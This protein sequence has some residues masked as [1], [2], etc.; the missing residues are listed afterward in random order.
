[1][2][3]G[4]F[5]NRFISPIFQFLQDSRAVGIVLIGCTILSLIIANSPWQD[6]YTGF[7]NTLFDPA[8]GHHYNYKGLH[9]PNSWLLWINDG[10]MALF[11]FLVGMEIKRELTT[12]ELASV[13]KSLL[14]I[15]AALGGM[16]MPALIYTLFNGNSPYAHGWGIPMATDIAF[17]LGILSLLGKRVPLSLKIFLTALAIIDDLGAILAIAIFYTDALHMLYLYI[18]AGVFA[19]LLLMNY[20]KVQRIILYVIPGLVLWYCVFN[21]GIHAT[22]A[23]VLL[24]FCI[25]LNKIHSLEHTLHD[26]VNFLIM[27]IFA[28]ANTAIEFPPDLLHAF[29]HSVSFGIIAG[30]VLGKP[31]GIFFFCLIAVRLKLAS[32]P[33][34][35]NWKQLWGVGMIAGVGFTMSIFIATLAFKPV[36]IQVISVMSVILASLLSGLAGFIFL[37][38]I[39]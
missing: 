2:S 3:T 38:A 31:L 25:P 37:R 1:M 21:S 30:L 15:L 34:N 10:F 22:I 28:L 17:S 26:P 36:D 19:L 39:K 33:A 24:A 5:K 32:L 4:S 29:T 13:K 11:F 35:T 14:P 20:L 12:G 27:P 9:L 8:G 6:A 7:F 23:G 16:L 18:G